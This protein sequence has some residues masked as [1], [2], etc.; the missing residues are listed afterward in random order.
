M[1][2]MN[3][4]KCEAVIKSPF[5]A[6]IKHIECS[7]CREHVEVND[8]FVSTKGFTMSR[9]EL[10][11]RIS[12]YKKL[13]FEVEN[14]LKSKTDDEGVSTISQKKANSFR[15]ILKELMLAARDN[16]RLDLPYDLYVEMNYDN[17]KRLGTL[18]NISAQGASIE[19][20]ERDQMPRNKSE[21]KLQL[22]LPKFS[23]P[24]S[25]FATVVWLKK[26]ARDAKSQYVNIGVQ[27]KNLDAK[28][29]ACLWNFIV[30]TASP[31]HQDATGESRQTHSGG[32]K[33]PV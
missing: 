19:I 30:E 28:T 4:P 20:L 5:L 2:M 27:Y 13:L 21:I 12:H 17:N 32:V 9:D 26:V 8:V 6:E 18:I 22:L 10:I 16:F 29:H 3:C 1:L 33:S 24:L 15:A 25:L 23:E 14:E 7:Q 31:L 11:S